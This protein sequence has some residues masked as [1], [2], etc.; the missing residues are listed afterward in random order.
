MLNNQYTL[1]NHP[2]TGADRHSAVVSRSLQRYQRLVW[3]ARVNLL[4]KHLL[5]KERVL[6]SLAQASAEAQALNRR[7]LG[8][9]TVDVRQITGSEGRKRDFDADFNP[10]STQTKDRWIGIANARQLGTPLPPVELIKVGEAY[11]VR[12]GHHRLS[13]ARAFGERFI[14]AEVVEWVTPVAVSLPARRRSAA[15]RTVTAS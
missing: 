7:F 2:I 14:D 6:L 11:F 8:I 5:G 9:R 4:V 13:V 12:D 1:T 15:T 10:L 3:A